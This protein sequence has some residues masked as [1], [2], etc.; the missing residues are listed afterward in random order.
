[1]L[2]EDAFDS[3]CLSLEAQ[4]R[5]QRTIQSYQGRLSAFIDEHRNKKIREITNADIDRW[6]VGLRRQKVRWGTHPGRPTSDGGLSI[7]TISTSLQTMKSFFRWCVNRGYL[8]RSPAAHL[9]R[10]P[11][12]HAIEDNKVMNADDL[13]ALLRA[14]RETSDALRDFALLLFFADTGVR[15]GEGASLQVGNLDLLNCEA[16][17]AGKTGRRRVFFTE[18]TRNALQNW[19]GKRPA[20]DH[21]FVWVGTYRNHCGKPLSGTGVYQVFKRLA[22]RAGIE[23]RFNPQAI[24]HLVGQSFVDRENLVIA[25]KKLGHRDVTT[26]AKFYAHQDRERIK[27]ATN[28]SSL[29]KEVVTKQHM[30]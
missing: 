21:D 27:A 10:I 24:R 3:Y 30:K 2:I 23:G 20:C 8:E 5:S 1:M 9:K 25:Q 19:L 14:A 22:R 16:V 15:A 18:Q 29:L 6:L 28:R 17:V 11:Y 26:T 13:S 12:S 7:A 4:G